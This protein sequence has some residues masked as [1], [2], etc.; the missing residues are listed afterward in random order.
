MSDFFSL[1][2]SKRKREYNKLYW[3]TQ[4][5]SWSEVA[6]KFNTN[7]N[8]VRRDANRLGVR[9][10]TKS[11]AQKVA[12]ETERHEHPTEGKTRSEAT[13]IKISESQGKVWDKLTE[14]ERQRRSEIG[15][16]SWDKKT[17]AEKDVFFKKGTQAMLEAAKRGS[18]IELYLFDRLIE[19]GYL[20][21]KHKDHFLQNE[22]LHIDLYIP[23]CRVAIEIDGPM[24]FEPIFGEE[25]LQKRQAADSQKNGLILSAGMALIRV[26]LVKRH[27]QR[28]LRDVYNDISE[29]LKKLS[30]N[31]PKTKSKRY[32][33]I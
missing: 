6:K 5:L 16:E 18:K 15:S 22:K 4:K 8:R 19:D 10:R 28:Y 14:S 31:F 23:S 20:P 3:G 12:I 30:K 7:P 27:S 33:E 29:I 26:K 32:F 13:K 25:K 24:H 2:D 11:E 9:S 1:S 21:D 17:K